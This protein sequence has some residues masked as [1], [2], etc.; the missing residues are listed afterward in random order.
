MAAH[1]WYHVSS[2]GAMLFC[3]AL[4]PECTIDDLSH[5]MS[6]TRRQTWSIV[7]ALRRADMLHIRWVGRTHHYT[8]NLNGPFRHPIIEGCKLGDV[9]RRL[10]ELQPQN[11]DSPL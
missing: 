9:L 1:D 6:L 2:H 5:M 11:G 3:I 8:V 10:M 7:A 4:N